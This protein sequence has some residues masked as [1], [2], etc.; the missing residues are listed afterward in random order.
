MFTSFISITSKGATMLTADPYRVSSVTRAAEPHLWVTVTVPIELWR[1][2][3]AAWW[4][5]LG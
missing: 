4:L 5:A 1:V 2:V 3:C